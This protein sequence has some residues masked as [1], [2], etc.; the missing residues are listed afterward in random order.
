[1]HRDRPLD[2]SQV[3]RGGRDHIEIDADKFASFFLMPE[4]LLRTRFR[5]LFLCEK[6][7]VNE[8][9][10]FALDPSGKHQLLWRG[11][12]RRELARIL[13]GST[14]YNGQNFSSLAEQ[15]KVSIEAMAIRIE[16]LDLLDT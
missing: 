13:A 12:T 10:A 6:F 1:M 2:G 14:S 4:K 16:E 5:R 9:T 3:D 15:F 8:A 11:K 7:T